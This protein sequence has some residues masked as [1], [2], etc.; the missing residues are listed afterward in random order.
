MDINNSNQNIPA[1][2]NTNRAVGHMSNVR[3]HL[4]VISEDEGALNNQLNQQEMLNNLRERNMA[5]LAEQSDA[6]S[7][8]SNA[9]MARKKRLQEVLDSR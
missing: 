7:S 3:R 6:A 4:D 9:Y 2:T 1:Q 5:S 8:V